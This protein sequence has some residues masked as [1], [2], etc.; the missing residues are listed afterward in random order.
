MIE[1]CKR[2]TLNDGKVLLGKIL[3]EFSNK[4][5]FKTKNKEY[6]FDN[7]EILKIEDTK[8]VFEDDS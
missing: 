5:Y 8:E 4:T 2:L 7:S 6:L 1:T 3:K